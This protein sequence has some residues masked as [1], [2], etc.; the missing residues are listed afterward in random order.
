[1]SSNRGTIPKQIDLFG[2]M[3]PPQ[4]GMTRKDKARYILENWPETRGKD[5]AGYILRWWRVYDAIELYFNEEE[6]QRLHNF[7]YQATSVETITRGK[8]E[9]QK[10]SLGGG[11]LPP[12]D[13][14]A[15]RRRNLD[16]AG[17][18]GWRK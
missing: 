11:D 13:D 15:D 3:Q 8:R 2:N 14:E 9:V 17:P 1:M 7:M 12:D 10:L 16:G 5:D 6:M 18:P 4:D